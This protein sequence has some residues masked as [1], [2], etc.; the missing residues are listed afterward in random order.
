VEDKVGIFLLK[1]IPVFFVF[2]FT[3]LNFIMSCCLKCRI[4]IQTLTVKD[5]KMLRTGIRQI[6]K[7]VIYKMQLMGVLVMFWKS[8]DIK[9]FT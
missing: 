1:A 8:I 9:L 3:K 6:S 7:E 2:Y 5:L 4:P